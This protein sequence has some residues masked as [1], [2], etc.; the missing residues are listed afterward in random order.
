MPK[1]LDNVKGA[2]EPSTPL[3]IE[4]SIGDTMNCIPKGALKNVYYNPNAQAT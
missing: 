2:P 1:S 4:K 3:H